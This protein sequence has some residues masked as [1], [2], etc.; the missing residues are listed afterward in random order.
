MTSDAHKCAFCAEEI[1]A[2]AVV[3]RY[4]NRSQKEIQPTSTPKSDQERANLA[5]S[6]LKDV[7]GVGL[8]GTTV[9]TAYLFF[10]GLCYWYGYFHRHRID[11]W[12]LDIP[13][14]RYIV[15]NADSL[16]FFFHALIGYIAAFTAYDLIT[17]SSRARDAFLIG[18]Q[19]LG[20]DLK[21]TAFPEFMKYTDAYVKVS[22]RNVLTEELLAE[23]RARG[24]AGLLSLPDATLTRLD[25][26]AYLER[27]Q[28]S[29]GA[30]KLLESLT[31][32]Q[33]YGFRLDLLVVKALIRK[34]SKAVDI[35]IHFSKVLESAAEYKAKYKPGRL[36]TW[37]GRLWTLLMLGLAVTSLFLTPKA[38]FINTAAELGGAVACLAPRL[39]KDLTLKVSLYA[40][41]LFGCLLHSFQAGWADGVKKPAQVTVHTK[42]DK[43]GTQYLMLLETSKGVYLEAANAP[44]PSNGQRNPALKLTFIPLSEVTLITYR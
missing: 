3:C 31:V 28:W 2:E 7:S 41:I 5:L 11:V 8:S 12:S 9:F 40:L 37:V 27:V 22:G 4:C 10:I 30:R 13:F 43:N 44:Q 34:Q 39:F 6:I 33:F 17:L 21:A 42:D 38:F 35:D 18:Y 19:S 20:L 29:P 26:E 32:P 24:E 36:E 16:A 23:L 14:I 15:P 1:K 25:K